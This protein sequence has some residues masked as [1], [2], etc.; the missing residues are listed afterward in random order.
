MIKEVLLHSLTEIVDEY[1]IQLDEVVKTMKDPKVAIILI[2]Q[3]E[4]ILKMQNKKSINLVGNQGQLLIQFKE[5]EGF[6]ETMSLSCSYIYFKI[7][8]HKFLLKYP[9]LKISTLP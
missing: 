3:F 5:A 9:L 7:W 1:E 2:Q 8:L 6:V 4:D